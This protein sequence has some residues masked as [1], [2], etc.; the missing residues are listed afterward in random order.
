VA[1]GGEL[2]GLARRLNELLAQER[3]AGKPSE[4]LV[5][6][7]ERLL[8]EL[9]AASA[10]LGAVEGGPAARPYSPE[11]A[12][13]LGKLLSEAYMSNALSERELKLRVKLN[14]LSRPRTESRSTTRVNIVS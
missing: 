4:A 7:K 3:A 9:E 8:G 2:A 11:V 14:E 5:A 10:R 13:E 12:A 6:E 1:Q